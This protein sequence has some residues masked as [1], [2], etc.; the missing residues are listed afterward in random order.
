VKIKNTGNVLH[1]AIV[2]KDPAADVQV[3]NEENTVHIHLLRPNE[4]ALVSIDS[5]DNKFSPELAINMKSSD[6]SAATDV[7][8]PPWWL[9][10]GLFLQFV[11]IPIFIW[12]TI[13]NPA[14]P[15]AAYMLGATLGYPVLLIV[16]NLLVTARVIKWKNRRVSSVVKTYWATHLVTTERREIGVP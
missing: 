15:N 14:S 9:I 7:E 8:R 16:L 6:M 3:D 2:E 1:I 5:D 13:S 12:L 10:P 4:A 11:P